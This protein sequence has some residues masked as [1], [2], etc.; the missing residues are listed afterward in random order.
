[1]QADNIAGCEDSAPARRQLSMDCQL[2]RVEVVERLPVMYY[3]PDAP[4]PSAFLQVRSRRAVRRG[5]RV[6][7]RSQETGLIVSSVSIVSIVS[8]V[9]KSHAHVSSIIALI[10]DAR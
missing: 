7:G 10:T 3:R 6:R 4:A 8:I 9:S 1:M 2:R 5:L